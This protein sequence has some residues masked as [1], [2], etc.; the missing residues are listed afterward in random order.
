MERRWTTYQGA[1]AAALL[2]LA[3]WYMLDEVSPDLDSL[4]PPNRL[5]VQS[6][7][8]FYGTV[9]EIWPTLQEAKKENFAAHFKVGILWKTFETFQAFHFPLHAIE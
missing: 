8:L 9:Q 4:N 5:F 6:I 7:R 2:H 3:Q 1:A